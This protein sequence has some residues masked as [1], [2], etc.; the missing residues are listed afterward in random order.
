MASTVSPVRTESVLA[1][2]ASVDSRSPP[3]SISPDSRATPR[4]K[5]PAA[6]QTQAAA[7][8]MAPSREGMR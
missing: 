1:M 6:P 2:K 4:L 7:A 3:P 5:N 8:S